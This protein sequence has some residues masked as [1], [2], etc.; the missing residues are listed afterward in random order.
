M[1][2]FPPAGNG[3]ISTPTTPKGPRPR[4]ETGSEEEEATSGVGAG[5]E[6]PPGGHNAD[7]RHPWG[8]SNACIP[9]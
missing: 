4:P 8:P 3:Q 1:D 9:L 6:A 2:V 5:P 7:P